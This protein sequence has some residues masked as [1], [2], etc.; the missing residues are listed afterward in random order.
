MVRTPRVRPRDVRRGEVDNGQHG[1]FPGSRQSFA[2]TPQALD[3]PGARRQAHDGG[4]RGTMAIGTLGSGS[5]R[6]AVEPH[7]SQR[8]VSMPMRERS[9]DTVSGCVLSW[10]G[11]VA[12]PK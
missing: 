6:S 7:A 4:P 12:S 5:T 11:V 10:S 8:V 1:G 3:R 2:K 9:D